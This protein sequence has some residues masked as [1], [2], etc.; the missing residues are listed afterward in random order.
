MASSNEKRIS[1]SVAIPKN[2]NSS[3]VQTANSRIGKECHFNGSLEF[4]GTTQIDGSVE[5][6]ILSRGE[7]VIGETGII[8]GC[9]A[10]ER[11]KIFG[12][13]VGNISCTKSLE[14]HSGARIRGDIKSPSIVIHDGVLFEGQCIMPVKDDSSVKTDKVNGGYEGGHST[15]YENNEHNS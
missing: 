9:I 5:G 11:V 10:T 14:F 4:V 15:E 6:D 1:S 2:L 12:Q 13:V 7:L 3:N 8:N